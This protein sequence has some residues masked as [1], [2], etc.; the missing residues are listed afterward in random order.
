MVYVSNTD[1]SIFLSLP[2]R[3]THTMY[4]LKTIMP[5]MNPTIKREKYAVGKFIAYFYY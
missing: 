4:L 2:V 1:G 3:S 5:S